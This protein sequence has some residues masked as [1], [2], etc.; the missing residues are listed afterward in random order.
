MRGLEAP[1]K[2]ET[3]SKLVARFLTIIILAAGAG[4]VVYTA[5][6]NQRADL[7]EDIRPVNLELEDT[8]VIEGIRTNVRQDPGGDTPVVILH[9][10]DVTGGL[11]LEELSLGLGE[12][13][14]GVRIDMPGFGYSSRMPNEGPHHTVAGLADLIAPVLE[15][16]FTT[17]VLVV[18]V[19][20]GG[21][22]GAELAL[23]Y[24]HLVDGFVMVD[25]DFWSEPGFPRSL[26]S[27]PWVGKAATYTWETGGR[28]AVDTWAPYC[29]DDGWC[30]SR[31]HLS[32]RSVIVEV[33]NT[34]DSLHASRRTHS[35]ALAPSN[36][37]HIAVPAAYVWSTD[38]PVPDDTVE[39]IVEE[40][41]GLV[42]LEA[43]VFQAHLED[44]ASIASALAEVASGA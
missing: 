25:T 40:M 32:V 31:E 9:D 20:L 13:F 33:E 14:H 27:I 22:V 26:E 10:F 39:R 34:T 24:A 16:R 35:A 28:F 37:D 21:Q 23:T 44:Q 6:T 30:P 7:T 8:T 19:G 1:P 2:S 4:I 12:D 5:V 41:P 18:G 15:E 17:P 42:V 36:L 29:G 38:G 3:P 11:I 43:D